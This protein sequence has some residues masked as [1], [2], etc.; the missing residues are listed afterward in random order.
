MRRALLFAMGLLML[1][2]LPGHATNVPELLEQAR[3]ERR[4]SDFA[5]AIATLERARSAA[6][7]NADVLLLLGQT[8]SF[9][10]R[11][12]E[13]LDALEEAR[14]IAPEYVDVRLA[15]ARVHFFRGDPLAAEAELTALAAA[16]RADPRVELLGGQVALS[17]GDLV[18]A[19]ARFDQART[20]APQ[21]PAPIVGL[22]D[23]AMANGDPFTAV[24]LYERALE[25]SPNDASLFDRLLRARDQAR[26]WRFEAD[27]TFSRFDDG[28][29][30]WREIATRLTYRLNARTALTGAIEAGERFRMRDAYLEFGGAYRASQRWSGYLA[31]GFTPAAN[32]RERWALRGGGAVRLRDGQDSLGPTL[33]TL[34]GRHAAYQAGAT[35]TLTPGAEQYLM[36][37]IFTLAGR[38]INV[39]EAGGRHLQ[40]PLVRIDA[41]AGQGAV[42]HAGFAAAPESQ[43]QRVVDTHAFFGG[44][45][46]AFDETLVARTSLLRE[47]REAGAARTAVTFGFGV[48]F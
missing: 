48:E 32:F 42:L 39:L 37:G 22:A 28:R 7:E 16:S 29:A 25:R 26:R 47:T 3:R 24:G 1:A 34:D 35:T 44:L 43:G 20:L 45:A 18:L 11:H 46:L 31:A 13:A 9:V 19:K 38:W 33:L 17:Q 12:A 15:I 21:S 5:S 6:A 40:G 30:A 41:R 14:A 27:L 2:S 8:L 23:V 10:A 4:D 36:E